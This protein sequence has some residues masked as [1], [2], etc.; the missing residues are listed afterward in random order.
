[1]AFKKDELICTLSE[2]TAQWQHCTNAATKFRK[3]AFVQPFAYMWCGGTIQG[4]FKENQ[5]FN[6]KES[7]F[8]PA[9]EMG[10][11]ID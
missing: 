10:V 1:M 9:A 6:V 3:S 8:G 2:A 7:F 11:L 4:T 5:P